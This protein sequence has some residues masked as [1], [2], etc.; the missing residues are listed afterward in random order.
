M[1]GARLDHLIN[2]VKQ[3]KAA[4]VRSDCDFVFCTCNDAVKE[5]N[6]VNTVTGLTDEDNTKL[7]A[8]IVERGAQKTYDGN[9][10]QFR[11]LGTTP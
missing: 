11:L 3:K 4:K 8:T 5:I 2:F 6:G 1:N 7:V 10:W 9:R